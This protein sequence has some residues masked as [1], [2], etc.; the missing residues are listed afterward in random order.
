MK[1]CVVSWSGGKDSALALHTARYRGLN[2]DCLFTMFD[3]NEI[4]RAHR[5]P[6]SVMLRQVSAL[7]LNL[8]HGTVGP[9]GYEAEF[10]RVMLQASATY[11]S[12]ACVFG[13]IDLVEHLE[14]GRRVCSD[15]GFVATYPLLGLSH[16]EAADLFIEE[17]FRA[18]IVAVHTDRLGIEWLGRAY[19][20]KT[21]ADLRLAGVSVAGE[22]G[23]FH[24]IVLDGPIFREHSL[25]DWWAS[26]ETRVETID[27]HAYLVRI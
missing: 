14:W 7:G 11:G 8:V 15:V 20:A 1:N 25:A 10:K 9:N 27:N 19:D 12:R 5:I 6:K 22:F 13:D 23:E 4:T 17:G 2:I 16:Q 26:G 24:T 3:T 18:V 21:I